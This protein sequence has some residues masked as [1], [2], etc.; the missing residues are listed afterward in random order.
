MSVVVRSATMMIP[1]RSLSG[2]LDI[3]IIG[4]FEMVVN[5]MMVFMVE[6]VEY[7]RRVDLRFLKGIEVILLPWDMLVLTYRKVRAHPKQVE[8]L[9]RIDFGLCRNRGREH[10]MPILLEIMTFE[11][12]RYILIAICGVRLVGGKEV[13]LLA[14]VKG[15]RESLGYS[16]RRMTGDVL[17]HHCRRENTCVQRQRGIKSKEG[18]KA[19]VLTLCSVAAV[20]L[21]AN[22]VNTVAVILLAVRFFT[23]VVITMI[24]FTVGIVTVIILTMSNR[25]D[26]GS[27]TIQK[28]VAC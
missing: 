15:T 11:V 10:S 8:T 24:V 21:E 13:L 19:T 18:V 7:V 9:C 20:V 12:I 28:A 1:M 6:A 23:M 5:M 4:V 25:A 22:R 3:Q 16:L 26:G 17:S 2:S 27:V 14:Q